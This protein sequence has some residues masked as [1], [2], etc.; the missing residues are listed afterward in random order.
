MRVGEEKREIKLHPQWLNRLSGEFEQSYMLKL[1]QFLLSEKRAGKRIFPAGPDI[2]AALNHTPFDRVKV[3][4]FGQDPYHGPGQA[5]GLCFSVGPGVAL[6]PSLANIYREMTADLGI[7]P[8]NHGNLS[9]WAE[10]GVLLLNSVLTVECHKA[11]SHRNRGWERFTD[12]IAHIIDEEHP[13]AAFVLWG[14]Y[15]QKKG[16]FINRSRHLVIESAHPSP[17]SASGG[18]FGS[19][20]FSKVNTWLEGRG[21]SPI[22]WSLPGRV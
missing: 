13:G 9:C 18:F 14:S 6:P 3:V 17:L 11:A 22:D 10:R 20:P 8:A 7:P 15:A 16:E 21:I 12:R 2:F 4:I 19:R 1:R 5:H